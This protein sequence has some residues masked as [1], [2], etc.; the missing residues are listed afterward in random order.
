MR[1]ILILLLCLLLV[2]PFSVYAENTENQPAAQTESQPEESKP[3]EAA[4]PVEQPAPA[5]EAKPAEPAEAETE[6]ETK[7]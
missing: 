3:A 5:P 1:K 6:G 4:K 7:E 2:L